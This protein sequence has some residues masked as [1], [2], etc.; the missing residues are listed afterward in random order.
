MIVSASSCSSSTCDASILGAVRIRQTMTI[1][2]TQLE[3]REVKIPFRFAFK[4]ALAVRREAHNLILTAPLRY[5]DLRLWRNYSPALPHRRVHRQRL[6]RY[7]LSLLA[8]HQ[9]P[10]TQD[11]QLSLG[12]SGTHFNLGLR[13]K[14]N[15][16]LCRR[17]PG[18][19]GLP[20]PGPPGGRVTLC[21]DN[22]APLPSL[23]PVPW[24][25]ARSAICGAPPV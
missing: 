8:C 20:G 14:K 18:R 22:A 17:G 16:R 24:A 13:P 6:G 5:R 9:G 15:R 12:S 3:L 1:R 7:Q 4:H 25:L 23:S 21:S 19:L 11:Q 2:F 10:A